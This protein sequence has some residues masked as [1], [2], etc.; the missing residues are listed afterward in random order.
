MSKIDYKA[1]LKQLYKASRQSAALI[2]VPPMN[3]LLID[4]AGNPNTS[5]SYQDAVAALFS[6]SYTIKFIVKKATPSID[7]GVMPLEGLWWTDDMSKFSV[8]RKDDWHWTLMIMQPEP[9]TR[10]LVKAA[11]E[12]LSKKRVLPAL[13]KLRFERFAEGKAAQILHVGPF[14]DEGPVI[15]HLHAFIEASG[16]RLAGKHHEIYLT[17]IRRAQPAKYKTIIRQ[18]LR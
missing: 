3:F 18:P 8:D 17:D 15:Q 5:Q 2:D 7:Y 9:V 6:L 11:T 10:A 4:G 14:S 16:G 13:A 12:Q 1:E